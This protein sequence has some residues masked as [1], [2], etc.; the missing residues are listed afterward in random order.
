[1]AVLRE[2]VRGVVLTAGEDGYDTARTLWNAMVDRKPGVIARC[3]GPADVQATVDFA[4]NTGAVLSVRGGGHNISG[5]AVCEGGVM[6]DLSPMKSVQIDAASCTARVEPGVKLEEFDREAQTFGLV[7]P[8]GIN[9]TTGI[10]GL[11]LGGGF[12]WTTRKFGLTVDNLISADVV[13][14]DGRLKRASAKENPEH[15]LGAAGAQ[16]R[17]G[18]WPAPRRGR[19]ATPSTPFGDLLAGASTE[20]SSCR[21]TTR[22]H[23]VGAQPFDAAA[24]GASRGSVTEPN[25]AQRFGDWRGQRLLEQL[26]PALGQISDALEDLNRERSRPFGRLRIYATN[27]AGAAVITPVWQRFLWHRHVGT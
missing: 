7:T 24:G 14:A 19:S 16:R 20:L 10:A 25:H 5:S 4:R 6:I 15:V 13:T 26:R 2:G 27:M 12:G 21:I 3:A 9:S 23:A 8:T 18:G 1:M 17:P 11:T 22:R